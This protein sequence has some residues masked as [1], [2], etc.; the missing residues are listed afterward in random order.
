MI[1]II[2]GLRKN[3]K[4]KFSLSIKI[5]IDVSIYLLLH[6][7]SSKPEI[8]SELSLKFKSRSSL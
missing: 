8:L 5:F 6:T 7:K 3:R 1:I 2:K 4:D